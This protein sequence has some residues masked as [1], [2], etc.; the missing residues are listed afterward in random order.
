MLARV[1][2]CTTVGIEGVPVEVEA[3]IGVGLPSFTI[4]G[5]PDAAVRESRERVLAALRNCG[6]EFPARRITINLAPAHLRKEGARFDL[7]IA[8][9]VLLASGQVPPPGDVRR[10]I[11]VGELALDGTLRPM[12]GVLAILATAR[13][14]RLGPVWL[15]RRNERDAAAL[16]E[17]RTRFMASL[18]ELREDGSSAAHGPADARGGAGD[19]HGAA[20]VP[21]RGA[22]EPPLPDLSEVR[23]QAIAKRALEIAAAGGHNLLLVG[24]PGAGKTM[25]AQRLPG[26]LPPLSSEESLEVSTIHSVAG[27]LPPGAG[28]IR[29]PPFRAPHHA[30]S[31]AGLIGGGRGL[32]PGEISLAHRG[33]LFLDEFPEFRRDALEALREPMEVGKVAVARA[34]GSVSF[35]ARFGL[36]AAMNPCPCGYRGDPRRD[37]RCAPEAMSRYWARVSGPILDRID[38]VLEV[39]ALPVKDLLG[40]EAGE[41]S[42]RV[43][44]RVL[45]ARAA[46]V[47]RGGPGRNAA[48]T[49]KELDRWGALGSAERELLERA[50][51]RFQLSAR[52][53]L[54]V[55]RVAR[56]IADLAGA[57][58]VGPDHLREALQYRV[59]AGTL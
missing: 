23:G 4:V 6:Y 18:K 20:A 16:P 7:P 49:A 48:A 39:P 45:A 8:V 30:V 13:R 36:V 17:V 42:A 58:S 38:L 56:T 10:A 29:H 3:D 33:I 9:A 28:L 37:C 41:P 51:A 27:S 5:L 46:A 11:F 53:L 12:A 59:P 47:A 19:G 34:S 26:I 52:G 44:A 1:L 40:R 43:S 24:P 22:A 50:M 15:P 35:P 55:R 32:K 54:R 21:P 31:P 25:L 57:E 14:R 2:S